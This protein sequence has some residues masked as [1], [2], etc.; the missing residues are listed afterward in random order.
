MIDRYSRVVLTVIAIALTVIAID[1]TRV[2]RA[3]AAVA[4]A[5]VQR[6]DIVSVGGVAVRPD[7]GSNLPAIP[8]YSP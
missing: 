4:Q 1:L 7:K 6:V 3:D 5:P 8:V 2:P